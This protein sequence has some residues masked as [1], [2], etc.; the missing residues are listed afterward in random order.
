MT[1][2]ALMLA[3]IAVDP[4]YLIMRDFSAKRGV[5]SS[6]F[7]VPK[8]DVSA[9]FQNLSS[10]STGFCRIFYSRTFVRKSQN[11]RAVD[12]G[13]GPNFRSDY[14]YGDF[15]LEKVTLYISLRIPKTPDIFSFPSF[16]G[17]NSV[18]GQ[19]SLEKIDIF[20]EN[21]LFSQNLY[22]LNSRLKM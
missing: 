21:I 16:S 17:R 5:T 20:W 4:Y 12:A 7:A 22:M 11:Q 9:R 18:Y 10:L 6:L 8:L 13:Q 15:L 3:F 1:S 2:M 14:P 19:F